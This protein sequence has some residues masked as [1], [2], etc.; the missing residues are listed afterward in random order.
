[1]LLRVWSCGDFGASAGNINSL[2]LHSTKV[3]LFGH[4]S[5]DQGLGK[6]GA[7]RCRSRNRFTL[8]IFGRIMWNVSLSTC[9]LNIWSSRLFR[10]LL[11]L[12][13]SA[14]NF[15]K[16]DIDHLHYLRCSVW[17]NMS[18]GLTPIFGFRC[19]FDVFKWLSF[20]MC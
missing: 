10:G 4:G 20:Q 15:Q 7:I 11:A 6:S 18:A 13:K 14:E 16:K 17:F 12:A 9:S 2:M 19:L 5:P 3:L 8:Y 1:M